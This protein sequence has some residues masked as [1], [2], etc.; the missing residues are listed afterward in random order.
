[1]TY[2]L[3]EQL[4]GGS[5]SVTLPAAFNRLKPLVAAYIERTF[6]GT[7][8]TAVLIDNTTPPLYLRP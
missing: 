2:Y 3:V 4:R 7:T 8:Q 6:P 5:G 1:M